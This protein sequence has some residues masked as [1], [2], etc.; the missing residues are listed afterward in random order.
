MKKTCLVIFCPK[1]GIPYK[2]PPAIEK[3]LASALHIHCKRCKLKIS[4][5]QS[6]RDFIRKG[7][8]L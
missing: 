1:C 8:N 2:V 5:A 4:V 6:L 7:E 3:E